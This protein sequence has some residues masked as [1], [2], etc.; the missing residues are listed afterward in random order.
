MSCL[1]F[2]FEIFPYYS[3]ITK[4]KIIKICKK[5]FFL[6]PKFLT[7]TFS[8]FNYIKTINTTLLL[9]KLGFIVI[10]HFPCY[11]KKK[12]I[13]KILKLYIN[14]KINNILV[15][16][17]D[18]FNKSK[19]KFS[20]NLIFYIK[21]KFNNFFRFSIPSYPEVHKN[22]IFKNNLKLIIEK[23]YFLPKYCFSQFLGN[24]DSYFNFINFFY[25]FFK[26]NKIIPG[27]MP[28]FNINKNLFIFNKCGV[29]YYKNFL[30]IMKFFKNFIF[31]REYH[32]YYILNKFIIN[33]IYKIHFYLFNN[34]NFLNII[35]KY[36]YYV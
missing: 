26:K 28:L 22:T 8:K 33:G 31:I 19:F 14:N 32:L 34:L 9:N 5:I 10:P 12:Y 25:L 6:N 15:L 36:L 23:A 17:G 35:I 18:K 7:I 2:S 30:L 21:K 13:L 1:S 29:E 4:K 11:F 24:S 16:K 27:L 20:N 3:I